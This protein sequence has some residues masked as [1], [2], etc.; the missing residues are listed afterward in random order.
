TRAPHP[1]GLPV[2]LLDVAVACEAEELLVAALA[3]RA[4]MVLATA[5]AGD[6]T[7]AT[8]LER[9]LGVGAERPATRG[10]GA[11]GA[12]QPQ[13]VA[14]DTP[15][16][17]PPDGGVRLTAWPGEAREC[18][19]IARAIQDEAARGTPFDRLAVLL[20]APGDY[21]PHLEEAFARAAIPFFFAR[22]ARRP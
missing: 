13:L 5:A 11:P 4:P 20:R 7:S 3:R 18:V 15:G 9:A 12:P 2:V 14:H 8:R 17:T 19:E 21:V 6:E 10:A 22:A 1:V 16:A